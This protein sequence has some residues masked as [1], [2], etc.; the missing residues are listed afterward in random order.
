[1]PRRDQ[2][3]ASAESTHREHTLE[4]MEQGSRKAFNVSAVDRCVRAVAG[5]SCIGANDA[6][7]S[8]ADRAS[9]ELEPLRAARRQLLTAS[10]PGTPRSS[11]GDDEDLLAL[12]HAAMTVTG[13]EELP[14]RIGSALG[15]MVA[16]RFGTGNSEGSGLAGS[17]LASSEKPSFASVIELLIGQA[18]ELVPARVTSVAVAEMDA[19]L[20]CGPKPGLA[21]DAVACEVVKGLI[22]EGSVLAGTVPAV[23]SDSPCRAD[24]GD[25]VFAVAQEDDEMT[26]PPAG[27]SVPPAAR[28][29][30]RQADKRQPEPEQH[31]PQVAAE[32]RTPGPEAREPRAGAL[33]PPAPPV[34]TRRQRRRGRRAQGVAQVAEAAASPIRLVTAAGW[35]RRR[36]WLVPVLVAMFAVVGGAA[37]ARMPKEFS[38]Q[39]VLFVQAGA[40]GTS[41]GN[42]SAASG[43][44][45]TYAGLLPED[46]AVLRSVGASLGLP[47]TE[48]GKSITVTVETNTSI[49]IVTYKA[50]SPTLAVQ[51]IDAITAAIAGGQPVSPAIVPQSL[52]VVNLA[53]HAKLVPSLASYGLPLGAVVGLLV[54]IVAIVALERADARVDRPQE[55][56]ALAGCPASPDTALVGPGA[57]LLLDKWGSTSAGAGPPELCLVTPTPGLVPLAFSVGQALAGAGVQDGWRL[58]WSETLQAELGDLTGSDGIAVAPASGYAAAPASGYAAAPASGYAAAPASGYV[59]IYGAPG[60]EG[61]DAAAATGGAVVM[62]VPEGARVTAVEP[63][64]ERLALLGARPVWSVLI[65]ASHGRH[66]RPGTRTAAEREAA[67]GSELVRSPRRRWAPTTGRFMARRLTGQAPW[68]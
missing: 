54:A 6:G 58:R 65:S 10:R 51:G 33:S 15:Q 52:S 16:S 43:L 27:R 60:S 35:A 41:P 11:R 3:P 66:G 59:T 50:T 40:S 23:L 8:D 18:N 32:I 1:M 64:L 14:R 67:G 63:A 39:A 49:M 25:C 19:V 20:R 48:V 56:A 42:P 62:V 44:A 53:S 36:L 38:A 45:T 17:G 57:A 5:S 30:Q 2:A 29:E 13:D 24:E 31:R 22:V 12:Y 4:A 46:A 21:H 34:V 28:A 37:A 7:G 55:L 61:G 47:A 9:E 68:R 26:E